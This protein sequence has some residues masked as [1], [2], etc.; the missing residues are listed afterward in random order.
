MRRIGASAAMRVG[1]TPV[2]VVAVIGGAR[3]DDDNMFA[4][5]AGL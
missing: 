5:V 3:G 2:G 4:V 1:Q